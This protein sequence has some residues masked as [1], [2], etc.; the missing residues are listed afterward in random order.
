MK[1]ATVVGARPQFV[2][3][4]VVSNALSKISGVREL[5]IHTGQHYD[6]A[7]S[8]VFFAELGIPQPACNLGVGS[9]THG[10]QTGQML[11]R[12]ERVLIEERPDW[13]LVYG[14]TNSTMAGAL[15]AA[16]LHIPL[17]HVEAGLRSFNRGMPEEL[18]R[19]LTDHASDLL[20]APTKLA[21][22]NLTREGIED[23]RIQ[24]VGD[25][26]YDATRCYGR[27]ADRNSR[28]LQ[29]LGLQ[30]DD[31]VLATIHRA[32]NTDSADRLREILSG[33]QNV[34][35]KIRVVLP[36]HP[37]T[38]KVIASE[39][40]ASGAPSVCFTEPVG[41][42]D[43]LMLEKNAKVVVTDSGGVQ[44]E[45]FFFSVPCVTVRNE[46]EWKELIEMGWNRLADA[47]AGA[48][49]AAVLTALQSK[50][51]AVGNP[52]GDGH[53]SEKIGQRL[54]A[55]RRDTSQKATSASACHE[56]AL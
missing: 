45:A 39:M 13:V 23:R 26:M 34:A 48:V 8:Q 15:A 4:S 41:Y 3:A 2:K 50:P 46:T 37:R 10:V 7:M 11:E 43:M 14:D 16:K 40:L 25:V 31:Y 6:P 28:V 12:I 54:I 32:E 47:E 33:L 20:F 5:V 17:A 44:K 9:G 27:L 51:G 22:A 30:R 35:G 19:I 52:Y 49:A 53:A 55:W 1:I 36:L 18:N 24:Q 29:R 21:V 42:L 56:L 38:Q